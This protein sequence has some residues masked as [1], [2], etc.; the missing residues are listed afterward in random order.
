MSTARAIHA[1]TPAADFPLEESIVINFH[2]FANLTAEKGQCVNSPIFSCA[3]YKW[4][5]RIY[6]GGHSNSRD[7]MIGIFVYFGEAI[8]AS[9]CIFLLKSG[10]AVHK[11]GRGNF[12]FV[13]R[14]E[15]LEESNH[16]LNNGALSF[17][18][19]L[20][21]KPNKKYY[22]HIMI[23]QPSIADNI[24]NK[25]FNDKDSADV[26][27]I[28]KGVVYYAHRLIL[29]VQA[30]ELLDLSEQFDMET[31]MP[32]N[33]VEPATFEIMLRFVYGQNILPHEWKDYSKSIL[34]ATEKYGLS[35][36]RLKA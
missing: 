11:A 9:Y 24:F 25:L 18:V 16:I 26:A 34:E 4:K 36:V 2:D 1:G 19:R 14:A 30:P 8:V 5:L 21:I 12:N 15:I 31:K 33:D 13:S 7:G 10:G 23:S 17:L 32:I 28:V 6:P 29:K 3:G 27:F 22:H 20:R 35:S